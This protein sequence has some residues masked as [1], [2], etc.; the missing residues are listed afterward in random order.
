[1]AVIE[2]RADRAPVPA[3]QA[4]LLLLQESGFPKSERV[5]EAERILTDAVWQHDFAQQHRGRQMGQGRFCGCC[6]QPKPRPVEQTYLVPSD[7]VVKPADSR[8]VG[9]PGKCTYCLQP[10]G[11]QH[12]ED[13]VIREKTVRVRMT[14]EFD[15]LTVESW[16]QTDI[17][18]HMNESSS[19]ADNL[20]REVWA[21]RKKTGCLCAIAY[22]EVIG[23]EGL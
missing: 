3:M 11:A 21:E 7:C 8:P 17:E 14:V 13:C 6:G 23:G 15:H 12:K 4:A 16:R 22:C 20:I 19:C 1:M 2:I 5:V 10:M 9:P 18:F